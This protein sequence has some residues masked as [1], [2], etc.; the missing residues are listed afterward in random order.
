MGVAPSGPD[1]AATFRV[2]ARIPR[3]MVGPIALGGTDGNGAP[4]PTLAAERDPC[5]MA[6]PAIGDDLDADADDD[7]GTSGAGPDWAAVRLTS[8]REPGRTGRAVGVGIR[9]VVS[10]S[11][12]G[13]AMALTGTIPSDRTGHEFGVSGA[14]AVNGEPSGDRAGDPAGIDPSV[15]RAGG[16]GTVF[17]SGVEGNSPASSGT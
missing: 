17:A 6:G 15:P 2:V 12:G 4:N 5:G 9:A 13:R 7:A 8:G 3:P 11:T 16:S 14:S 10:G 1:E